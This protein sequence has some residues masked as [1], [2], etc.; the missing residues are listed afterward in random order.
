VQHQQPQA[1]TGLS[2]EDLMKQLT[3]HTMQFEQNMSTTIEDLK[4]Q[5]GQMA[6]TLNELKQQ[7]SG[8]I[9]VQ[10]VSNPL[11]N[12]SVITL[13][14]GR[15]VESNKKED[16]IKQKLSNSDEKSDS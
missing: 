16:S 8:A 7:N 4:M 5:M 6:T 13:R 12:V 10:P 3:T 15:E 9:P 14:N 11:G 1:N 2:L